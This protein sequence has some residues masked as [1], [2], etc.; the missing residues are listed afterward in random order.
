MER[1][2]PCTFGRRADDVRLS[3]EEPGSGQPQPDPDGVPGV[4]RGA[5]GVPCRLCKMQLVTEELVTERQGRS[6]QSAA[7]AFMAPFWVDSLRAP[8]G[9]QDRWSQLA[10]WTVCQ[11]PLTGLPAGPG[12]LCPA[13]PLPSSI[14]DWAKPGRSGEQVLAVGGRAFLVEETGG[15]S[16]VSRTARRLVWPEQWRRCGSGREAGRMRSS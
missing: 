8:Q 6:W 14:P 1:E 5:R 13:C 11:L 12:C 4:A 16:S 2:K 7:A 3:M 9:D 15:T 10:A